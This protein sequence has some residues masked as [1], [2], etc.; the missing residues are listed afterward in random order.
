MIKKILL[1]L[2]QDGLKDVSYKLRWRYF[3]FRIFLAR[4]LNKRV[5]SSYYGIKLLDDPGDYTFFANAVGGHGD[6]LF[7]KILDESSPFIFLDIGA[8]QGVYSLIAARN[9]SCTAVFS[10]EPLKR[11]MS[12]LRAN[13][14]LNKVEHKI[15][16]IE[17][18]ISSSSGSKEIAFIAGHSGSGSLRSAVGNSYKHK[19]IISTI[20]GKVVAALI[21]KTSEP[22]ICKI[23]VEGHE[24]EV[25]EQLLMQL[26]ITKRLK[27]LFIEC[28]EEWYD[29]AK[30][31]TN[32]KNAGFYLE[33][34][35]QG[36]H[37][38]LYAWR[39]NK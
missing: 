23:D 1:M 36:T 30:L 12:Y 20:D 25:V 39:H 27:A 5:I 24:P 31:M 37:Y 32:L 6:F 7:K 35:G 22:L 8:N 2:K 13:A 11:T 26:D 3:A 4:I 21:K 16:F 38:D 14:I 18:A 29:V 17:S 33:K 15:D 9:S 28:D 34:I 19:S 10:F